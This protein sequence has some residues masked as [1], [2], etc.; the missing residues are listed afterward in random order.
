MARI[1]MINGRPHFFCPGC[2]CLHFMDA[3]FVFN[4]NM[5]LPTFKPKVVMRIGPFPDGPHAGKVIT[6]DFQVIEG[7]IIFFPG[8]THK[9]AGKKIPLPDFEDMHAKRLAMA[10]AAE[11][12]EARPD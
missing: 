4:W 8:S 2:L 6:C 7:V 12:V 9:E 3:R 1:K 11:K 10:A 5:S